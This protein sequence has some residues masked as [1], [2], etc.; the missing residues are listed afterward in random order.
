MRVG[1][2]TP[3]RKKLVDLLLALRIQEVH[4]GLNNPF[5]LE[6]GNCLSIN[7]KYEMVELSYG[8]LLLK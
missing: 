3:C 4:P 6:L 1:W 8:R 7:A 2:K 5:S